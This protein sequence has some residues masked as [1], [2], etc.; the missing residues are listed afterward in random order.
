MRQSIGGSWLI[1]IMVLFIMIFAGYIILTIDYNKSVKVKNESISLIEK[2]EGLNEQSLTL[3]N[4]YLLGSGYTT[5]GKCG[6]QNYTQGGMYGAVDLERPELEETDE[7]Q[8][9]Y[10]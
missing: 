7:N 8:N 10:Y 5:T 2:Y 3:L 1:G 4:N 6:G 9:Y